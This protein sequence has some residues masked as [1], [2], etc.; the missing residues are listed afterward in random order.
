MTRED[1]CVHELLDTWQWRRRNPGTS[2]SCDMV[3]EQHQRHVQSRETNNRSTVAIQRAPTRSH[4]KNPDAV[5]GPGL[6]TT[7]GV[8]KSD[9]IE[10]LSSLNKTRFVTY[11]FDCSNSSDMKFPHKTGFYGVCWKSGVVAR[12]RILTSG[13][14]IFSKYNYKDDL[15]IKKISVISWRKR[16]CPCFT[17]RRPLLCIFIFLGWFVMILE[18]VYGPALLDGVSEIMVDHGRV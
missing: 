14:Q 18:A 8:K 10:N 17:A 11:P 2:R 3:T 6:K 16:L 13:Y 12:I 9:I 5:H 7:R 4:S 15:M 1:T